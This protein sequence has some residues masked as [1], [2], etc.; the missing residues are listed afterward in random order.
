MVELAGPPGCE[1][2]GRELP[3]QQGRGRRRRYCDARCRDAARRERARADRGGTEHVKG[4]S[5]KDSRQDYLDSVTSGSDSASAVARRVRGM[6][7]Q[8]M[9]EFERAGSPTV[10]VAAARELSAAADLALQAAIDRARDAG[11]SWREIGDVVGTTR[12]AAFQ[13]F[14]Y[15]VDPRTGAPMSRE[16]MPGTAD[17]AVRIFVCHLEGRWAEICEQLDENMGNRLNPDLMASAW[18]R[19]AGMIGRLERIGEPFPHR[20]GDDTVVE[21]PLCFEAADAVGIVRFDP[22]GKVAGLAIRPAPANSEP[23]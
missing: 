17:R 15:P 3:Q 1:A 13:R 6:V 23:R 10:A 21:I 14:G 18:A 22:A 12:Q 4:S 8:L 7:R 5:T 19:N 11:H 16:V 20:V 2:C 9:D